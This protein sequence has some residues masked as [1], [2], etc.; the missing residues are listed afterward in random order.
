MF[1]SVL[2]LFAFMFMM[3]TTATKS[4]FSSSSLSCYYYNATSLRGKLLD[5]NSH[6]SQGD[7]DLVGITETWFNETVFD[8]EILQNCKYHIFRRDRSSDIS[9]K[10]DGGGVMLAVSETLTAKS[11]DDLTTS[12]EILWVEIILSKQKSLFVGVVYIPPYATTETFQ[13]YENSLDKVRNAMRP[14]DSVT[15]LGDFNCRD[16]S[17]KVQD[18][19]NAAIVSDTNACQ[20]SRFLLEISDSH[21]LQQYNVHATHSTNI[22]DLVFGSNVD[23]S[24]SPSENA[25]R[26]NHHALDVVLH[27]PNDQSCVQIQRRAYNFK[28]ANFDIVYQ[29]LACLSWSNLHCFSTANA[30]LGHFYDLISA[31]IVDAIPTVNIRKRK[32]PHWYDGEL[33]SLVIEKRRI[34]KRYKQT[35]NDKNSEHYSRFCALRKSVKVKQKTR[36]TE[37]I[38]DLGSQIKTNPKRFWSYVKDLKV[39]KSLPN[40][41][42]LGTCHYDSYETIVNGFNTFFKSV[43]KS[44]PLSTPFCE[45]RDVP[46]FKIEPITCDEMKETLENLSHSTSS[47][48]DGIPAT[49]LIKC[50]DQL[51]FPLTSIFNMCIERG[52][53]PDL[54]KFNNIVPIYKNKGKKNFIDS[55]RGISIQPILAKVFESIINKRLQCHIKHLISDDQHGFQPN[56]STFTNLTVYTDF[57]SKSLDDKAEVHSIY[58]DFQKAFDVVPHKLLLL[59]LQRQFGI[60]GNMLLLFQSYLSNRFQ[61]VVLNGISSEWVSVTSGV[62]QGSIIGPKLFLMYVNDLAEDCK[63][64]KK[65]MF[66]DDSKFF[67]A[68]KSIVDCVLLQNDLNVIF[69]WCC[70]WKISLNV[71]KC[72]VISFSNKRIHK[73]SF[74]YYFGT[75]LIQTVTDIKDLGVYFSSNLSFEY[76]VNCIVKKANQMLG[77]VRR[78]TKDIN[79]ITVLL[80]LY[81]TLVLSKLEYASSV[82]SPGQAFLSLKIERVQKRAVKWL[83]FKTR[84][85]Y[86]DVPYELLCHRFNLTSLEVRRK[87]MDLRNVNKIITG[88]INCSALLSEVHWYTPV[89]RGRSTV[90]FHSPFR[91]NARGNTFFPR[92]HRLLNA[93]PDEVNVY[94]TNTYIF[95]R[96]VSKLSF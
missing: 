3:K 93:L 48:Y 74:P 79:D 89:R 96:V 59:K 71:D 42:F 58:T 45:L 17:W 18:H 15:I 55:Y 29:L 46:L 35:G 78:T 22:L 81:R 65:L 92:T 85:P 43:F 73:V 95:K 84:A 51:S 44:D 54:L 41:M 5:F 75:S 31:V 64:S 32:Y 36:Y 68:I 94:E 83:S 91:I 66:A 4:S 11:R 40:E 12:I 27:L 8:S 14:D 30:A 2:F 19:C 49:F 28:R 62:P 20:L 34:H 87:Q 50:A 90:S 70:T 61:R 86:K 57:L 33:I 26:S 60:Q 1:S 13:L 52:E 88:K 72:F 39:T 80:S 25:A 67:R 37:Y 69:N 16:L 76:H 56:K 82:W 24:V 10:L 77:F 21:S 23:V 6:F 53:Y 47:G 9:K 63:N 7:Y 38:T